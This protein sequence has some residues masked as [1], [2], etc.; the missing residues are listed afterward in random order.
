MKERNFYEIL[1]IDRKANGG[2]IEEAY[3]EKRALLSPDSITAKTIYTEKERRA[4]FMRLEEAYRV[5]SNPQHREVYDAFLV[6]SHSRKEITDWE[7]FLR[8]M[9]GEREED[10]KEMDAGQLYAQAVTERKFKPDPEVNAA[11]LKKYG[12]SGQL[13]KALR[14]HYGISQQDIYNETK[15]SI[16]MIDSIERETVDLSI[17]RLYV[18]EF[19]KQIADYFGLEPE[20]FADEYLKRLEKRRR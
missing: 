10:K 16:T 20:P 8:A 3:R 14:Q 6:F 5:L 2:R 17:G 18:E 12:C 7:D 1:G 15:I 9:E 4:N 11:Y 13:I 19:L